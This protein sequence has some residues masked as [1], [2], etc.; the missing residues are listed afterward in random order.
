MNTVSLRFIV[1]A[2]AAGSG[3]L[4][5]QTAV[6]LRAQSRNV[7]F[8][9]AAATRPFKTGATLPASCQTGES[10]FKTDAPAGKNLY[11]CTATDTWSQLTG[12]TVVDVLNTGPGA[13][14]ILKTEPGATTVTA[15]QMLSGEGLVVSQQTDTVAVESDTAITPRYATATTAPSGACQT[16]RDQFVR[17][18][19]FPHVYACVDGAWK[20]IYAV[21][22]TA[23][24]TCLAGEFYFDPTLAALFG[25]TAPNTWT[26]LN[27]DGI[28]LTVHGECFLTYSCH[29][30]PASLRTSLPATATATQFSAVRVVVPYRVKLGRGLFYV[31]S[32]GATEAFTAAV[33]ADDGG[34]PGTKIGGT[35]LRV[36]N[37]A[38]SALRQEVWG[39]G[40]V[41]LAPGVYWVGFSSES[42]GALYHFVAGGQLSATSLVASLVEPGAV[43]CGNPATGSGSS[44]TL[45]ETCGST[46]PATNLVDPPIILAAA[47]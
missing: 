44:Y 13:A 9:A 17:T 40:G 33:Y 10:F 35:D 25:C 30:A 18:A 3:L 15:R 37:L 27:K 42:A 22:A 23:P 24:S 36:V 4:T 39:T 21:T 46:T 47:Q 28:D 19:G 7:D 29:P 5:A 1:P 2:L 45:P 14:E 20:P 31:S 6:D 41:V 32:G 26:R 43:V 38:A 12:L 8:S 34:V 16:G 11:V